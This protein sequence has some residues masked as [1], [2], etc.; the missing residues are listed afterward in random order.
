MADQTCKTYPMSE[1]AATPGPE[2]VIAP[3]PSAERI[4]ALE[5]V[6]RASGE[7]HYESPRRKNLL[8]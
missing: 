8:T 3:R 5:E 2:L 4:A 6:A 7:G 1:P